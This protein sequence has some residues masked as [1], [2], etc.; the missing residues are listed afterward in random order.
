M[1]GLPDRRAG[2]ELDPAGC[3]FHPDRPSRCQCCWRGRTL[4]L[5]SLR[6]V[7]GADYCPECDPDAL[8]PVFICGGCGTITF[9]PAAA[10]AG[11]GQP[12]RLRPR[13]PASGD[14]AWEVQA[15]GR[16]RDARFEAFALTWF[17][18]F[19]AGLMVGAPLPLHGVPLSPAWW[20][21][22]FLACYASGT[23]AAWSSRR[24]NRF[25]V[26]LTAQGIWVQAR[27][28]STDFLN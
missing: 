25:R 20:S 5:D 21:L 4:C 8:R 9:D 11:C 17:V 6:R 24:R 28:K 16:A 15:E 10:C 13:R 19:T 1:D 22:L 23:M 3:Y 14:I 12:D 7:E 18:V 26:F 27:G 2:G